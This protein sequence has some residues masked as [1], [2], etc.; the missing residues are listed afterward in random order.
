MEEELRLEKKTE[1]AKNIIMNKIAEITNE[2]S[3][4]KE[5]IKSKELKE[6]IDV[7]NK[8]K[9]E[10]YLGNTDIINNVIEKNRKGIL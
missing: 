8:I 2:Y 1:D 7:L 9:E 10:I 5:E 3:I 6:K 4:T